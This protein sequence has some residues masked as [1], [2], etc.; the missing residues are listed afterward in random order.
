[1]PEFESSNVDAGETAIHVERGG[2][3]PAVLLLH[4]F[5]ETLA[6][7]R[8]IAAL[9]A[10]C[11]S[12]VCADLRG[13]GASGCPAS[14]GDHAPYSKRALARD[15]VAVMAQLGFERFSIAGHDRGG[16]VAYRAALDAP[17][18]VERLAVL[19]VVPI[20]AAWN[21]ADDR[22]ALGF[23]PWS[24]LAQPEPLPERLVGAAPEAVINDALSP[25]WGAP[26]DTFDEGRR[27]EYLAQLQNPDHVHAIC[28]E[29]RAAA[30]I[31]REHD[32]ADRAAGRRIGCPVLVLWSGTG[33]LASWYTADGGP[34][35]LWRELAPNV[36]GHPVDGGHFFPEERPRDTA[37]ALAAFFSPE[38]D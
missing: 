16:R 32:R 26:A 12:V 27:A 5:P 6:M 25:Q 14:A 30:S 28:E 31:D 3:G 7:W 18:R 37:E 15:M 11:F 8:E 33:P 23:W 19:D 34:L 29:Y 13:Y 24:L 10:E 38:G 36:T 9:L 1:M 35:E 4:G 22:L 2:S 17:E 20:D 21:R